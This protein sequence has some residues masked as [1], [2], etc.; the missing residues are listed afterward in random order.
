M[1]DLV[2]RQRNL[3]GAKAEWGLLPGHWTDVPYL[4]SEI[5]N[6]MD[7]VATPDWIA[8]SDFPTPF[9]MQERQGRAIAIHQRLTALDPDL[10]FRPA[11]Y[12]RSARDLLVH[13]DLWRLEHPD[14][15]SFVVGLGDHEDEDLLPVLNELKDRDLRLHLLNHS[16]RRASRTMLKLFDSFDTISYEVM[17]SEPPLPGCKH[18]KCSDCLPKALAWEAKTL[19][20]YQV[21][22][23]TLLG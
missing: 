13:A 8:S 6:I 3:R 7:K 5:E 12:G 9:S 1:Q 17:M 20:K 15:I 23:P 11:L 16:I 18:K 22:Q 4:V 2:G 19:S 21:N 10:P 14:V